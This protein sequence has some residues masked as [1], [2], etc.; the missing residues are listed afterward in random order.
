MKSLLITPLLLL[1]L[2]ASLPSSADLEKGSSAYAIGDYSTAFREFKKAAEEGNAEAQSALA[3][4]YN[5]GLGVSYDPIYA[6]M[7]FSM[8]AFMDR[9]DKARRMKDYMETRMSPEQLSEGCLTPETSTL[10]CI[11]YFTA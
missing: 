7:W 1:A 8:A 6:Y 2:L 11:I 4:M 3:G 9:N 5:H 10:E